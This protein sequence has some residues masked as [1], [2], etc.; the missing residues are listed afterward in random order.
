MYMHEF[1]FLVNAVLG[2]LE[3]YL[4]GS[5]E[6]S[7]KTVTLHCFSIVHTVSILYMQES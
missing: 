2:D 6:Q 1:T 3:P 4:L 5:A 7:V